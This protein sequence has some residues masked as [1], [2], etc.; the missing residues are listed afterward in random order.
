MNTLLLDA[1]DDRDIATAARLLQQGE[2]VAMPT[3]TVYGLAADATNPAAVAKIFAAK[4]RPQDNPLIVHVAAFADVV[5]YVT[6]IPA[7]AQALANAFCPGPLT[8]VLPKSPKIP[9]IVSAGLNSVAVRVPAHPGAQALLRQSGLPLA[10]PSANKSGKP[11]PTTAA[12]VLHDLNGRIAAVLNGGACAVGVEST[13]LSL[14]GETPVLLRPGGVSLEQLRGILGKVE[15]AA[16]VTAPLA[17]NQSAASPGMKYKH[18]APNAELYL[19]RGRSQAFFRYVQAQ[20]QPGDGI[21]CYQNENTAEQGKQLGIPILTFG[22]E[23]D[24]ESQMRQLFARLRELD[25]LGLKR[26]FARCPTTD[27]AGLAVYNRLLRAAAFR[28]INLEE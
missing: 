6:E 8:M 15:V 28:V 14:T 12:H 16:A 26:V 27:G 7:T 25:E 4:D 2:L 23:N 17:L 13:V 22:C 20:Q 24:P 5:P 18:Y 3:E 9:S 21:L 19:C 10:A 1:E 11:S